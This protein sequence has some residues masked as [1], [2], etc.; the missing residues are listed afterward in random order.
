[1][2]KHI[3]HI[4]IFILLGVLLI[5][6]ILLLGNFY[7]EKFLLNRQVTFGVSFAPRYAME[8]GLDPKETYQSI[9]NELNVKN[10]RLSA[11]WDEIEPEEGHFDFTGIDYYIDKATQNKTTVDLA[12]GYKLPR[13]PECRSPKWLNQ[14]NLKLLREKQLVM[15]EEVVKHYR[16]NLTVTSFQVEN[17]PLLSFGVCPKVDKEFFIKE[18]NLVRSLTQK[19]IIITDSGELRSWIEPMRQSDTF[20]TTLYRKV[21]DKYFG[22]LYYPIPPWH[23]RLKAE[24]VK[25]LFAPKNKK[26]IV[27]ELQAELWAAAPLETLPLKTQLDRFSLD[28]FK[29]SVNYAKRTG[30]DEFYLWGVE[31]WYYLA[32]RGHPEYLEYAKTLF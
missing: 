7:T 29:V 21:H 19:T 10:L 17:E 1:M 26:T 5:S 2:R 18:V 23:Y 31:W 27:S 4:H 24:V 22:D 28:Q 32:A 30:F 25:K 8:L 12:V 15:V 11:Y 16:D 14:A 20:G 13:W 6:L 3:H 9:L